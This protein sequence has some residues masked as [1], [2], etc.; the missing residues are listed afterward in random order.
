MNKTVK[1][2]LIVAA[3]MIPIG[4]FTAFLGVTFGGTTAW[5]LDINNPQAPALTNISS[6]SIE[7]KEFDT[8]AIETF[9]ADVVI[10]SG[11]SYKLEYAAY[12]GKD[13]V[14]TE[15]GG[16]LT[17]GQPSGTMSLFSFGNAMNLD[18]Y[19]ITV[20]ATAGEIALDLKAASGD[21]FIRDVKVSGQVKLSSGDIA[22]NEIEG[23]SIDVS[24]N[25]GEVTGTAMDVRTVKLASLSGD[26][27]VSETYAD[28]IS[29]TASSGDVNVQYTMANDVNCE[30]HSGDINI[31]L[32]GD[33]EEFSYDIS[34][35]SGD[36]LVNDMD[37]GKHYQEA[38]TGDKTVKAKAN[39]G[40]ITVEIG[41]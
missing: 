41:G 26:I 1:I 5:A 15:E 10:E 39:S 20:P 14:M 35:N 21:V 38:G 16:K 32:S 28:S 40:D 13:P 7:L 33:M 23:S 36:I 22:L 11:D 24:T 31:N 9:S 4:L 34:T 18:R 25:S 30:T 2:I 37:G 29:C 12:E 8:L 19:T 3:C 27:Q 17:I 6:K